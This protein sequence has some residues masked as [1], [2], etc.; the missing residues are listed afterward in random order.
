MPNIF[1]SHR[2]KDKSEIR[3]FVEAL[4]LTSWPIWIDAPETFD[5]RIGAYHNITGIPVG[6]EWNPA[7]E[8]ALENAAVVFVFWTKNSVTYYNDIL[9]SSKEL[10]DRSVFFQEVRR[11]SRG[12]KLIHF[13]LNVNEVPAE[14]S[15]VQHLVLD[16]LATSIDPYT[17]NYSLRNRLGKSKY[18]R[19]LFARYS[20]QKI[21][22]LYWTN[23]SVDL[24]KWRTASSKKLQEECSVEPLA[25]VSYPSISGVE[26][27][28]ACF[29]SADRSPG[30]THDRIS[31]DSFDFVPRPV[32]P[33]P[34]EFAENMISPSFLDFKYDIDQLNYLECLIYG[35]KIR[36][37][38]APGYALKSLS[39][40]KN[41]AVF[42]YEAKVC[43][44][45][46]NSIT[47][48]FREY[49][50]LL[51]Y[52]NG[53]DQASVRGET[54]IDRLN[55]GDWQH[56]NVTPDSDGGYKLS[57][58]SGSEFCS[59][60]SIQG[61]CVS[62]YDDNWVVGY[63]Q[64]G[65]QVAISPGALQFLPSGGFETA[66]L[67]DA[68]RNNN[69]QTK[70]YL[71]NNF[72]MLD[73]LIREFCEELFGDEDMR[74]ADTETVRELPGY[75]AIFPLIESGAIEIRFLGVVVD[76]IRLRPEFSFAIVCNDDISKVIYRNL[77][78][79]TC[80]FFKR[81]EMESKTIGRLK[82]CDLAAQLGNRDDIWHDTSA[83]MAK[84][85][86]DWV[87]GDEEAKEKFSVGEISLN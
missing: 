30:F 53:L 43:H 59:L 45:M 4:A 20:D 46:E 74:R 66:G 24:P 63:G 83:G 86:A 37:P 2:V 87:N 71:E 33:T 52:Q 58:K 38:N 18:F 35:R 9:R 68:S 69:T 32:F 22:Q 10:Q 27:A 57:F 61:F 82:L 3:I 42:S 60:I 56:L 80:F 85:F 54:N 13:R 15:E 48:H 8:Q 12:N 11:S 7:I 73:A 1:I 5:D 55:N 34:E 77:K 81:N 14:F 62:R 6:D 84:L 23:N 19:K 67:Q 39:L 21:E 65:N 47:S 17:V 51:D 25:S 64:R 36:Y 44:Y 49:L 76:F 40:D 72:N 41:S 70:T 26:Y 79:S 31:P 16:K 50:F 75:K 29:P 28:I 78:G